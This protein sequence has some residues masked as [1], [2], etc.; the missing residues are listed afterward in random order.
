MAFDDRG[1]DSNGSQL[2]SN[3]VLELRNRNLLQRRQ[4][5][6]IWCCSKWGA[7]CLYILEKSYYST[8]WRCF[9]SA[10]HLQLEDMESRK[11]KFSIHSWAS[12]YLILTFSVS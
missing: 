12:K 3:Q 11:I 5:S 8:L 2:K 4:Q 1:L 9:A 10:E 6:H 7:Y